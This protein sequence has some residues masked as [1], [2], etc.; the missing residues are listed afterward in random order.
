MTAATDRP[1]TPSRGVLRALTVLSVLE[2][3]TLAALLINLATVHVR[4]VTQA[5]G[6]THGAI[7]LAVVMIVVFAPGFRRLDRILG[8]LP[9]IGGVVALVQARRRA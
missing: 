7:Y 4:A 8:C 2:V 6:P 5:I 3:G 1:D 9:V